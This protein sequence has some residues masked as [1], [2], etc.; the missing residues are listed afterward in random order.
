LAILKKIPNKFAITVSISILLLATGCSSVK[1]EK[2][3]F[4]SRIEG[5]NDNYIYSMDLDGSNQVKLARCSPFHAQPF[6]MWSS[7][8]SILAFIDY[9]IET[10]KS[11]LCVVDAD[12][13]NKRRLLE[14]TDFRG[15]T[16]SLAPDG[17]TIVLSRDV[18]RT[19]ETPQ[20]GTIHVEVTN[21]SDLFTVNVATGAVKQLTD[22]PDVW[23]SYPAISPNGKKV[24]FVAR[25]DTENKKGI[26]EYIYVMDISGDNRRELAYHSEGLS[27]LAFQGLHWSPD[28]KKIAYSVLNHSISD[29]EHFSD[30]FVIDVEKGECNNLTESPYIVDEGI[31]WSPDSSKISYYSGA[32]SW[33]M[34]ADGKNKFKLIQSG[35]S[36]WTPD[37]HGLVSVSPLNVYEI[38]VIDANG[39]NLR[40]LV[41][42]E[43]IRISNP[44]WLTD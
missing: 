11:W 32:Y 33:I 39:E 1:V 6:Q 38:I 22:T 21:D 5:T 24:S 16:M 26:P 15:Y 2:L 28:S 25:I 43:G 13:G 30:I 17:R 12:G 20:G 10:D 34:D 37:G 18:S 19:I 40:S 35:P 31:S 8:G 3:V 23:E 7:D 27:L 36:S 44:M 14:M 41:K 42:S 29:Y 9:D 4:I